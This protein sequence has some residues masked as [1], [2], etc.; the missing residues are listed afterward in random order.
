MGRILETSVVVLVVQRL[1]IKIAN[2]A[3]FWLCIDLAFIPTFIFGCNDT[4][5]DHK[6]LMFKSCYNDFMISLLVSDFQRSLVAII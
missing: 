4:D 5:L 3:Y 1:N 6:V 2:I